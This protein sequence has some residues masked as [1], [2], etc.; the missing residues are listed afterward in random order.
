[1]LSNYEGVRLFDFEINTIS[2]EAKIVNAYDLPLTK[3]ING[4]NIAIYSASISWS[5]GFGMVNPLAGV[6]VG[7]CFWA[8][9]NLICDVPEKK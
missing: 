8:L 6:L 9:E 2:G 4:C 1:M 3:A 5:V 7:A